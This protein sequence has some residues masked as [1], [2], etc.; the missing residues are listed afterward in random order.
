MMAAAPVKT[1]QQA[2]INMIQQ[3]EDEL[4]NDILALKKFSIELL[5]ANQLFQD[6]CKVCNSFRK[7]FMQIFHRR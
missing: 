5:L 4:P 2:R 1:V 6:R 3:I 7:L